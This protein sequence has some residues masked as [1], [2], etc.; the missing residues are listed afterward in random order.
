MI[1]LSLIK[2]VLGIK[3]K[4]KLSETTFKLPLKDVQDVL[5]GPNNNYKL[6]A[7]VS[8]INGDLLS[9]DDLKNVS[10]AIQ[11][12]LSTFGGRQ[13]IY[14]LSQRI[15]IKSNIRNIE[16]RKS[17]LNDEFKIEFLNKQEKDFESMANKSRTV[18]N[19]YICLEVVNKSMTN[20]DQILQ[21]AFISM[22]NELES[23]NLYTERLNRTDIMQLLYERMNPEQSEVEPFQDDWTLENIYPQNA[24]RCADGRELEIENRIYRFYSIYKFP[25]SVDEYRWLRKLLNIKGDV[26]IAITMTPKNKSTIMKNLSKA[27]NEAGGKALQNENNESIKQYYE[28]EEDSAKGLID[29]LGADNVSLY[30]VNIT[31]GIS[32]K[33]LNELD[34]LSNL[35]QSKISS[36]YME[37]TELKEK[38]L[39]HFIQY[40]LYLLIIKLLRNMY[41]IYQQK[42]LRLL[43]HSTAR[44]LWNLTG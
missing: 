4:D 30:D 21:D 37:S 6:L 3:S 5:I 40:Y 44:N 13:A 32:A 31:I 7:K 17:E 2:D 10:D 23:Q 25:E 11:A 16:K 29:K 14:I 24:V 33:S 26:S 39:N 1:I 9:D 42:I 22:K 41:G 18:L 15:D 12:A 27:V 43:S 38:I 36:S 35:L 19:F 34:T 8:P 20:A 28:K